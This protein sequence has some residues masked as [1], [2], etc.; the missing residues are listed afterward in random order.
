MHY[1]ADEL[2]QKVGKGEQNEL[3]P[4]SGNKMYPMSKNIQKL[5]AFYGAF[6]G[7]F[8]NFTAKPV[9]FLPSLSMFPVKR[10]TFI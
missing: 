4:E 5:K 2:Q 7:F 8:G 3:K 1:R 9:S 6:K 10:A